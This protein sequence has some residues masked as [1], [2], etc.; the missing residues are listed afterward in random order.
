MTMPVDRDALR[1]EALARDSE[2]SIFAEKVL[3]LLD[4]LDAQDQRIAALTAA[5]ERTRSRFVMA[6]RRQP[7]RD[8]DETLA[9]CDA[10]LAPPS[11]PP[12]TPA[13]EAS[14]AATMDALQRTMDDTRL[15]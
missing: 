11:D 6:V 7:I 4:A 2:G 13:A 3:F 14:C 8:V 1:R 9:E 15:R 5:L 10:A 12:L